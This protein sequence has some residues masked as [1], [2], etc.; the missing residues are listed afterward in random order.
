MKGARMREPD[1]TTILIADDEEGMRLSMSGILE[2]EGYTVVTAE[3]GTEALERVRAMH[4]DIAFL[5]IR[6]P[7]MN[8]V[9]TFKAIKK[10]SPHTV[11]IM[12]TAYAVNDLIKEAVVEGAYT[13]IH[14]P[15]D[16]DTVIA[17]IREISSKP[18]IMVIDD[19]PVICDLLHDR[20]REHGFIVVTQPSG[21]DGIEIMRRKVPDVLLLDMV[22]DGMDGIQTFAKLQEILGEECPKTFIIT[23]HDLPEKLD[24]A[25]RMGALDCLRKPI[26]FGRL[27]QS[28]AAAIGQPQTP[29]RIC[30]VDDDPEL[31]EFLRA[32]LSLHGYAVDVAH[33]GEE[34]LDRF[35]NAA[36][37]IAVVNLHAA[38]EQGMTVYNRIRQT[39]PSSGVIVI[40]NNPLDTATLTA[41]HHENYFVI[42]S[43]LI[44]TT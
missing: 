24:E 41:L 32:Q 11:V 29:P 39:S 2:L 12:M 40:A 37:R 5:D 22:M 3:D 18:M 19:D 31:C 4:I 28:I 8:G 23:A 26:D 25:R 20:L 21:S 14:K 35:S 38:D 27:N 36:C 15:F 42:E 9:E 16:M 7:G 43:R 6:M 17:T 13:C 44:L 1:T 34:A 10:A 33:S 30:V